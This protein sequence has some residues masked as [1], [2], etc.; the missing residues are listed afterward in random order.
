MTTT[1]G[2]CSL[3]IKIKLNYSF[4]PAATFV[5]LVNS[6]SL[7]IEDISRNSKSG[8]HPGYFMLELEVEDRK[9]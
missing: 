5:K 2:S 4:Q 9:N 6:D 7:E 8:I 3:P 1:D